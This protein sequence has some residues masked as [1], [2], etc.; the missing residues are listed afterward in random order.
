MK[1]FFY[2]F[3]A[4]LV[5]SAVVFLNYLD[6]KDEPVTPKTEAAGEVTPERV[7]YEEAE[8][9]LFI[10]EHTGKKSEIEKA[11]EEVLE[12]NIG[13]LR[14]ENPYVVNMKEAVD[15]KTLLIPKEITVEKDKKLLRNADTF[16]YAGRTY[17]VGYYRKSKDKTVKYFMEQQGGKKPVEISLEGMLPAA[18]NG[19]KTIKFSKNGTPL[20]VAMMFANDDSWSTRNYYI[21]D[22]NG[23]FIKI[24]SFEGAWVEERFADIDGDKNMEMILQRRLN[25]EPEG[26]AEIVKGLKEKNFT[27]FNIIFYEHEIIKW[28]EKEG[29]LVKAG[30]IIKA[31]FSHK[32]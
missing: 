13:K 20:L 2:V 23:K 22:K 21:T 31:D 7:Y 15:T 28:S 26:A 3:C 1:I 14:A 5:I 6:N 29:K 11:Y 30:S 32:E 25:W 19:Y 4:V 16:I 12:K 17:D 18:L 24:F 8:K 9:A 27:G 10:W